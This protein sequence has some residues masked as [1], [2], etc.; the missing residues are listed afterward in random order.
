MSVPAPASPLGNTGPHSMSNGYGPSDRDGP[1]ARKHQP[2]VERGSAR[3][4]SH[5]DDLITRSNPEVDT[6]TPVSVQ[7]LMCSV[8]IGLVDQLHCR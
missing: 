3:V 7:H 5:L 1:L 2:Y 4:Y 6:H 8:E